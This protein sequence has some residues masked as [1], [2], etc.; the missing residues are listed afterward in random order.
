MANL[1]TGNKGHYHHLASVTTT[2]DINSLAAMIMAGN[3]KEG[4][5]TLARIHAQTRATFMV[6][7]PPALSV[8]FDLMLN[9]DVSPQTRLMAA[10]GVLDRAGHS[11]K[12]LTESEGMRNVTQNLNEMSSDDIMKA[13]QNIQSKLDN[14]VVSKE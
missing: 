9:P 2:D 12:M 10:F 13:L 4:Y 8:V 1:A 6:G 14:G 7:A 5:E 3:E 11:T